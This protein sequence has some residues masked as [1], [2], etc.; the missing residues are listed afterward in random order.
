MRLEIEL[1]KKAKKATR[2]TSIFLMFS[3][4]AKRRKPFGFDLNLTLCD[5][6]ISLCDVEIRTE[7]M[8]HSIV[9]IVR[10]ISRHK[11]HQNRHSLNFVFCKTNRKSVLPPLKRYFVGRRTRLP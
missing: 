9:T 8:K 7:S 2:Q 5:E 6:W 3:P 4:K 1:R 10:S 11:L